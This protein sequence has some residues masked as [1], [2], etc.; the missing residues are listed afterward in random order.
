[1]NKILIC[2]DSAFM[3]MMIKEVLK[4]NEYKIVGEAVN[5]REG[6]EKYNVLKPDLVLMDLTMPEMDGITALKEI[7][8]NDS[9]ANIIILSAMGQQDKVDEALNLG[10]KDFIV[11]PFKPERLLETIKKVI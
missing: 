4:S 7:I 5:G 2:D 3:R 9:Q 1:M 6:I 8:K 11:K 10:A